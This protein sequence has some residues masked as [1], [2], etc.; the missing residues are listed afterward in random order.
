[1]HDAQWH[2]SLQNG[3]NT[4]FGLTLKSANKQ[5]HERSQS[6][7]ELRRT[8]YTFTL[9]FGFEASATEKHAAITRHDDLVSA[10]VLLAHMTGRHECDSEH[11]CEWRIDARK[12]QRGQ[13]DITR[14]KH[15]S[16]SEFI[17]SLAVTSSRI[18]ICEM[19]PV[20]TPEE[21]LINARRCT[22]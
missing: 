9:E 14:H 2:H 21:R 11:K 7:A 22:I 8:S 5:G 16:E 4:A 1:L 12:S 3:Q 19:E 17:G 20:S 6:S 10:L 18:A 13:L 15:G